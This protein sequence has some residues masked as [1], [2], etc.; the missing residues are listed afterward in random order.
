MKLFD[1]FHSD[2]VLDGKEGC[3]KP[4]VSKIGL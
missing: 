4:T 1:L 2:E 3:R